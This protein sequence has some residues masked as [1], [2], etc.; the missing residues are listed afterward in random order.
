MD[1][2]YY[3]KDGKNY[4]RVT[5]ILDYFAPPELV[6]WK[7]RV[8]NKEAN[9]VSK[10]AL[11]FGTRVHSLIG[12]NGKLDKKD[13][14]EVRNCM[15]AWSSWMADN[16]TEFKNGVTL[17]DDVRQVAGTPDLLTDSWLVD[18][19]TSREVKPTHFA[20]LGGYA[21]LLPNKPVLL[22]I[23]RLDKQSGLYEYVTNEK[24]GM[25]VDQCISAFNY[26]L[27]YYRFHNRVQSTLKPN[28]AM[29]E[30]EIE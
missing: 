25:T 26:I 21:S 12:T 17:Y 22:A 27:G 18:I 30:G 14:E 4:E 15:K 3:E 13:G 16:N 28:R 6:S 10:V 8:G 1:A 5:R 24:I 7:V 2:E 19:K 9:R 29:P 11:K 23:L 20:Q